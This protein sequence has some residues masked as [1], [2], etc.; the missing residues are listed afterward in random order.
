[1][2][3]RIK[4]ANYFLHEAK[5]LMNSNKQFMILNTKLTVSNVKLVMVVEEIEIEYIPHE[6]GYPL[7]YIA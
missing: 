5:A 2:Q 3:Q 7:F 4:T 1:M 6:H